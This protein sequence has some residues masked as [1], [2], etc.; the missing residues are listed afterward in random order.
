MDNTILQTRW[1]RSRD[2]VIY[3]MSV[4]TERPITGPWTSFMEG[5]MAKVLH[6]RPVTVNIEAWSNNP[7]SYGTILK[8]KG[9][10][11]K[12]LIAEVDRCAT[13]VELSDADKHT[14]IGNVLLP[15]L[16]RAGRPWNTKQSHIIYVGFPESD[17]V[18]I[19]E[20]WVWGSQHKS[21]VFL[22]NA[23][24]LSMPPLP[25]PDDE[26]SVSIGVEPLSEPIT[27]MY[28]VPLIGWDQM[29]G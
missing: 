23:E 24:M 13:L 10:V 5:R 22:G 11:P 19:D 25:N 7:I 6:V 28:D 15:H 9:P 16:K 20:I 8:L 1:N 18:V 2:V 14:V 27:M 17:T 12:E 4:L 3:L 29:L 21:H 26:P